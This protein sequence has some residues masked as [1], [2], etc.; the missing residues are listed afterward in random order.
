MVMAELAEVDLRCPV[1]SLHGECGAG[2]LLARLRLSG[3]RPSY[4]HPDNLIEMSCPHCR[5]ALR[6]RGRMIRR[7]LHRYNFLGELVETLIVE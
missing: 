5:A 2:N 7:V 3:E 4:V 6:R 1:G